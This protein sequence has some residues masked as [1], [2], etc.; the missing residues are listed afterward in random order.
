MKL[1]SLHQ[2]TVPADSQAIIIAK[3]LLKP[4]LANTLFSVYLDRG[5]HI[6]PA[7]H[8]PKEYE[9]FKDKI[10]KLNGVGNIEQAWP[11]VSVLDGWIR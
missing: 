6:G 3:F 11:E 2:V 9:R 7:Q 5:R 4:N 10:R 8:R 1:R